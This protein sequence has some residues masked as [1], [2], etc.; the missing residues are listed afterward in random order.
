[1][2]VEHCLKC[3]LPIC[4][5]TL[6]DCAYRLVT[7]TSQR[8]AKRKWYRKHYAQNAEKERERQREYRKKNLA[9]ILEYQRNRRKQN[10]QQS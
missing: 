1:M 3:T 2:S 9:K 10:A 6:P 5:E 7:I 8:P 4:D